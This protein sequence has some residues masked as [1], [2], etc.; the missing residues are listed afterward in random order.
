MNYYNEWDKP[1]AAWLQELI[2]QGLIPNGHIDTRSIADVQPGDLAG[3]TQCHFFAGIGGWPLALQLAGWPTDRYVWSAS[4]PC[5]PWSSAGK[6]QG[7]ADDRNLWPCFYRLWKECKPPECFG[8]QSAHAIS[9]GWLD[10]VSNDFESEGYAVGAAV[11]PGLFVGSPQKRERI[12]WVASNCN[13]QGRARLEQGTDTCQPRQWNWRGEEDLQQLYASPY[14]ESDKWPKPLLC[15]LD[16]GF[17]G[18]LGA[19]HGFGNAII[20]QV[21]AEFI[22]AYMECATSHRHHI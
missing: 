8:E 16:D 22:G 19:L 2:N 3:Y 5:Q 17:P 4:L 18:R 6:G 10:A 21:A 11:L 15:S 12:F 14:K 20:P 9:K 7:E 1:T 13:G